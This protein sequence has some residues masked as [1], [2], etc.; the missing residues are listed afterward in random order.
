MWN[1]T[2]PYLNESIYNFCFWFL[3]YSILG[4][5]AESIYMSLCNRKITNRGFINGPICPIYGFVGIL[6][7]TSLK[8]FATR[9]VLLFVF[10]AALSTCLELFVA[11]IMIRIF[12]FVWWD[13]KNKPLN[14]KGI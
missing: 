14:Y 11:Y 4:W 13:Y 5:F 12:G 6:V 8:I 7:H 2:L 1:L 10:G 9:P 3:I